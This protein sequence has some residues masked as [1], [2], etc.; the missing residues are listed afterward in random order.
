MEDNQKQIE[1]LDRIKKVLSELSPDLVR[2]DIVRENNVEFTLNN[3]LYRVRMPTNRERKEA[4]RDR[5]QNYLKLI[6]DKNYR[7]RDELIRE[8]K[9]YQNIDIEDIEN[10]IIALNEQISQVY[11]KMATIASENK[12]DLKRME[13]KVLAKFN[14]IQKLSI[15]KVEHLSFCIE[16]EVYGRYLEFLIVKC[17]ERFDDSET[18]KEPEWKKVWDSQEAFDNDNDMALTNKSTLY[19]S[20]LITMMRGY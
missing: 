4:E 5:Q 12:E 7:L 3:E 13:E 2:E 20:R 15:K 14:E 9:Q 1:N 8:L 16:E 11:E 6:K 10:K 17:T 18:G 19:L